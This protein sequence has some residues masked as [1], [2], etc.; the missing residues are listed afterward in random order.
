MIFS[1]PLDFGM[2]PLTIRVIMETPIRKTAQ[3]GAKGSTTTRTETKLALNHKILL[4]VLFRPVIAYISLITYFMSIFYVLK[5]YYWHSCLYKWEKNYKAIY[6]PDT[7][8]TL[9]LVPSFN[10]CDSKIVLLGEWWK[11]TNKN[12]Q[13]QITFLK[14]NLWMYLFWFF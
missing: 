8:H 11:L 13:I 14:L 6:S 3:H 4:V 1:C 5:S 7:F 2:F 9:L 10:L 12:K